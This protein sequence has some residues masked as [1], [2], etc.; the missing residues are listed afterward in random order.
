MKER[1]VY[2]AIGMVAFLGAASVQADMTIYSTPD[3]MPG[4]YIESPGSVSQSF[5]AAFA[6]TGQLSF[7]LGGSLSLDGVSWWTDTFT[8]NVNG[9]DIFSGAFNLGGGGIN[10]VF[11]GPVGS[12]VIVTTYGALGDPHSTDEITWQ[13]GIADISLP[14]TL[15]YGTNT[16]TFSYAGG[17]Q[18]ILDEGWKVN[19][20]TVTAPVPEA[21]EWVMMMAGIPFIGWQIRRRQSKASLSIS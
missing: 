15:L 12:S 6:G 18:G 14:V 20:V 17:N 8:L 10:T 9:S 11:G 16:L 19:A 3:L 4:G 1:T 5:L 2:K 21:E 7:Q 13:G